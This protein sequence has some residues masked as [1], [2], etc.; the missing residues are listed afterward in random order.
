MVGEGR[1]PPSLSGLLDHVELAA[2]TPRSLIFGCGNAQ[3][4]ASVKTQTAKQSLKSIKIH[5]TVNLSATAGRR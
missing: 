5:L 1:D 4:A 3:A 2:A